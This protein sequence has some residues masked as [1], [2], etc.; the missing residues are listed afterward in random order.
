MGLQPQ[1]VH[2]TGPKKS[3][4]TRQGVVDL[5]KVAEENVL[6]PDMGVFVPN[7][8]QVSERFFAKAS[9]SLARGL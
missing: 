5:V 2:C 3:G 4:D 7:Q 6:P 1:V 8:F 9:P